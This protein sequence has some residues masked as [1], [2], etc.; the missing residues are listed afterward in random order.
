MSVD[1]DR[2]PS[3]VIDDLKGILARFPGR[4]SVDMY[5]RWS[6]GARRLRFGDGYRVEPQASLF[7]ELK[8]LLGED[9]VCQGAKQ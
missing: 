9:C 4:C 2:L 6:E 5:V 7:A 8:E 1:G 3:T